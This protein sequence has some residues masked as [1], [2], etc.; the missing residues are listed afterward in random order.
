M[1]VL[2]GTSNN[3]KIIAMKEYL[4]Q[5]KEK[6]EIIGLN[7]IK[8]EIP[9]IEENFNSPLE[10][11]RKKAFT[12]YR[13]F[14]IPV[15]SCDSGLYIDDLPDT[16]QPGVHV[17]TINGVRLNDDEMIAY[18]SDLS[19]SHGNKL[20]CRYKNAICLVFDDQTFF[21]RMD[22]SIESE[23]FIITSISHSKRINGFPLDSL[24]IDIESGK[25]F[26]DIKDEESKKASKISQGFVKFFVEFLNQINQKAI[27]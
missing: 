3:A 11:A 23:K 25:Y 19:K 6:I 4:E 15:F 20:V 17:R 5:L 21:E 27:E 8:A 13:S 18:Y 16:L 1:K 26:Y 24:S 22:S 2:Y 7:D 12:Y 9:I 14:H 10:N